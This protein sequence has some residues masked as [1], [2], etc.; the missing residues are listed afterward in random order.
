[1]NHVKYLFIFAVILLLFC[2][3]NKK[4]VL[5]EEGIPSLKDV[6]KDDFLIGTAIENN[7]LEDPGY[8]QLLKKH[9][10]S[11]TAENAMKPEVIHPTE[12][13]FDFT[14]A[15]KIVEFAEKNNIILRGHTLI[16]HNQVPDWFFTENGNP[17]TKSKLKERI[18]NHIKTVM[19][20]YK[21]KIY[22]W[23]VVNE[24]I[25]ADQPDGLRKNQ[26]YNILG[27]EY[28]E[29]AFRYAKEADPNAK[30]FLNEYDTYLPNK[31]QRIIEL[32]KKLRQKGIVVD[33]VGMQMHITL[34]RPVLYDFESSIKD[35]IDLGLEI[36]I[37]EMDMSVYD[38]NTSSYGSISDDILNEQGHRA[39]DIFDI[40]KKYKKNIT[41]VTFWG[42]SDAH[43]WLKYFFTKRND[44]PLLF[45][46]N[47]KA[48]PFYWG[49]VD[50]SKLTPRI[51][52]AKTTSG[53]ADIDGNED[54]IWSYT[55]PLPKLNS[56]E[57]KNTEIKTLWDEKYLY[58]LIKSTDMDLN[59][60]NIITVFIDEKN[61]K[62]N[63]IDKDDIIYKFKINKRWKN[64]KNIA[65]KTDG[66]GLI[67]EA[68]IPFN[69]VS[70]M[71]DMALGFDISI[72]NGNN[73]I[74]SWNDK[75]NYK[76]KMPKYWGILKFVNASKKAVSLY[77]NAI[78]DGVKDDK[79]NYV[80]PI[81]TS[82]FIKGVEGEKNVFKGA[83]AKVWTL[84]D[85]KALYIYA[86]VNDPV[87]SDKNTVVYMQDS[88]EV[89]IDENNAKTN[90]YETDDAQYR[91]NFKNFQS[92]GSTGSI[93]GFT[94]A[95]K[96][97][98]NGYAVEAKIPFRSIKAADGVTIGFDFQVNDDQG[99]GNRDSIAKWN[100]PTNDSWQ[101]TAGYGILVF[102]K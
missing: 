34:T 21:G 77:G 14:R 49:I 42:M 72:K 85:D 50:P 45:D 62:S 61:N 64:T 25:D 1:M 15:D 7:E 79:Y 17:V 18:K 86:E 55:D 87:L 91:I 78:I 11:I 74:L 33:G 39:G 30:L 41:N 90:Y 22:A 94:S 20:R 56:T 101:S 2:C 12:D 98:D 99:S 19:E 5:I 4:N 92:F 3:N 37:T 89:F 28:I 29:L 58:L 46:D 54:D 38:D 65:L 95:V 68:K 40:L 60:N 13:S 26:W 51:I 27:E 57:Y 23:D 31:K 97:I 70:G 80:T 63:K 52:I 10:S 67:F 44:W 84:W 69:Y 71:K 43:T 96:I 88:I 47:L 8:V 35:F 100:D 36:H 73:S 9:F 76:R 81:I 93:N 24:P 6:F 32:I 53:S 102:K 59:K 82:T 16:W 48:K 75:N 66:T 83:T